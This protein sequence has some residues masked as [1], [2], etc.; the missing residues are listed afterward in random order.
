MTFK[1][2]QKKSWEKGERGRET[3]ASAPLFPSSVI[4]VPIRSLLFESKGDRRGR[5]IV[6]I[7]DM[8]TTYVTATTRHDTTGT[9][10]RTL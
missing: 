2:W 6:R 1:K 3:V 4:R 10:A 8:D 9:G 5:V 7:P